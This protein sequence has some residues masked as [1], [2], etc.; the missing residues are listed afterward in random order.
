MSS[1]SRSGRIRHR[2]RDVSTC[3]PMHLTAKLLPGLPS[4]RRRGALAE[5]R[6]LR[7]RAR[8]AGVRTVAYALMDDHIHWIVIAESRGALAAAT[9]LVFG[10][11]ARRINRAAGRARGRVFAD[12]FWSSSGRS[13]RQAFQMV[14]YVLR[15]PYEA[16]CLPALEGPVDPYLGLD[17]PLL[18]ADRFLRSVFGPRGPDRDALLVR[19]LTE[20][21]PF[22]PLAVRRQATLPGL[23]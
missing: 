22:V 16:A 3:R 6:R 9:R 21:V 12:R 13:V 11:L 15:N 18:S 1:R 2:P 17:L 4:L 10:Q 23:A 7:D 19:M 14:A 5:F 20:R 8:G